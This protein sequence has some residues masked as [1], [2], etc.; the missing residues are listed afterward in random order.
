MESLII[1]ICR[2]VRLLGGAALLVAALP[3]SI[4]DALAQA[5]GAC[6]R[7]CLTGFVDAYFAALTA[8]DARGLPQA[9]RARITENGTEK[10]LADTLWSGAE[11]AI[12]RFD[13]VNPNRGD[14]GTA[15]VIRNADGSKT[16]FMVRLKVQ[17]GAITEVETIKANQGDADRLWDPDRLTMVSE[18]LLLSIRESERDSYYDLIGAAES[19]WRAFQTNGTPAYRPA[20][21]LPD[22]RRYENGLQTTGLVRNGEFVSTARGFDEGRFLGRNIWDRRYPVVDEERGIVLSIVRFGLKAGAQS[23]SVATANDRL[24]AEF[25]AIKNGYIQEIH[26]VLFNLPDEQATG[27]PPEHGPG[28]ASAE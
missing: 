7:A 21:L 4:S 3:L 23:Q 27:W 9:A 25:F 11:E 2:R 15:A 6:D 12:Y 5:D 1:R 18:D 19:Y 8:A 26:A 20:R 28:R 22:S 13:A 16:M 14:T 10:R 17:G 24:V